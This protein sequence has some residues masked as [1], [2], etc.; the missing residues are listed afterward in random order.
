MTENVQESLRTTDYAIWCPEC[1]FEFNRGL[2]FELIRLIAL[3]H[4]YVA[5]HAPDI[6]EVNPDR[7]MGHVNQR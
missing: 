7:G 1:G 6:Y 3:G 5:G 4:L 2:P